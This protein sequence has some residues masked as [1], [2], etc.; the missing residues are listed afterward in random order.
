MEYKI[1]TLKIKY[2]IIFNKYYYYNLKNTSLVKYISRIFVQ[3]TIYKSY[4]KSRHSLQSF[5]KLR[6]WWKKKKNFNHILKKIKYNKEPWHLNTIIASWYEKNNSL[7]RSFIGMMKE[8]E[9]HH[10][11]KTLSWCVKSKCITVKAKV[12]NW[13]TFMSLFNLSI[14]YWVS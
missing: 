6:W 13:N 2:M 3:P 1:N 4:Y 12:S 8:F 9:N 5:S 10:S 7:L 11:Y 14:D